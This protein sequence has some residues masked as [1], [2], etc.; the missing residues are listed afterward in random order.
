MKSNEVILKATHR[1]DLGKSQINPKEFILSKVAKKTLSNN[2][3]NYNEAYG[4]YKKKN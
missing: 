1:I 4:N 2:L 3:K